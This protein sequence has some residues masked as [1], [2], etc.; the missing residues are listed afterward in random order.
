MFINYYIAKQVIVAFVKPVGI[1]EI[2]NFVRANGR[3]TENYFVSCACNY[4]K[5]QTSLMFN[6]KIK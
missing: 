4:L 3:K 1:S 6:E 5:K 2:N